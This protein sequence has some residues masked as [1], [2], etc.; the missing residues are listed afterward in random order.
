MALL[1]AVQLSHAD[2]QMSHEAVQLSCEHVKAGHEAV[3]LRHEDDFGP[4]EAVYAT[5]EHVYHQL[6]AVR[7]PTE[8]VSDDFDVAVM[9]VMILIDCWSELGYGYPHLPNLEQISKP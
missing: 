6:E 5:H 9:L 2:V 3:Q 7:E 8:C 4:L 1:Y